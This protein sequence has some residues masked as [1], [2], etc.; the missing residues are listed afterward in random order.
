M[1]KEWV[2]F[3]D[4]LATFFGQEKIQKVTINA[5]FTCPTRDGSMGKG[6]CTYCNNKSFSPA[7]SLTHLPIVEQIDK[8]LE[9]FRKRRPNVRC[10][11]YFQSYTNT[12]G[13]IDN[14]IKKY[15]EALSHTSV[16][17]II[18]GTRP[19]CM[20]DELLDYLEILNRRTFL[21]IEYG[22]ESTKDSTL[23]RIQR[24]HTFAVS[25]DTIKKTADRGIHVGAHLILG[26]PSESREDMINHAINISRLPITTIK[27][28]HLQI[29][30]GTIMS[31]DY[32]RNPQDYHLFSL[33]EYIDL[34]VDF[35]DNLRDDIIVERFAAS[36]PSDL[37]IAPSWGVKNYV[38]ADQIIKKIKKRIGI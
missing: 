24:G 28:H 17:G 5:G 3:S 2:S 4:F 13:D 32:K 36:A 37:L 12:Y 14:I 19:D 25:Q 29:I 22:V 21:M 16:V 30:K 23:Y 27:L 1:R 18:V 38:I 15:E 20:P 34:C 10:L 8:G 6:G 11:A 35:V 9:F 7:F 33:E 31:L 26:L